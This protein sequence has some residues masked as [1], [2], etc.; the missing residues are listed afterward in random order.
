[1]LNKLT[2]IL[3][4][5]LSVTSMV[6]SCGGDS[7]SDGKLKFLG[8]IKDDKGNY[9]GVYLDTSNIEINDTKRKFWIRY[10]S[11]DQEEGEYIRQIGYWEVDCS[12]RSLY[13]IAEEYYSPNSKLL[14][15][16]EERVKEEYEPEHSLGAKM[17]AAVCRYGGG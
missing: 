10:V 9:I 7:G 17:A 12:D 8:K 5:A 15:R 13:R 14:G 3:L 2:M 6:L 16:S 11:D 1:M 4:V